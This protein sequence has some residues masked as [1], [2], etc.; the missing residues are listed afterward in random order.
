M[1]DIEI[2]PLTASASKVTLICNDTEDEIDL[3]PLDF[4]QRRELV[5]DLAAIIQEL[6]E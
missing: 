4:T 5:S 6:C 2:K 3:G 1:I